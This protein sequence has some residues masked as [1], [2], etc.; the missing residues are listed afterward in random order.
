MP[1]QD[2]PGAIT[3]LRDRLSSTFE[4]LVALAHSQAP[5][6]AARPEPGGWTGAEVLEHIALTDH[7]L[8]RLAQKIGDKAAM[9]AARGDEWPTAPPEF[10]HLEAIAAREH[11]WPHPE[12]MTPTGEASLGEVAQ[13]LT[14]HLAIAHGWLE[15][16]PYGE[17]TLHRIRM[18]VVGDA[19]AEDD[20]LHLYQFLAVIELHARRHRA[21]LA[22]LQRSARGVY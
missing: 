7:F 18:S 2:W 9:R 3:A 4:P 20:R 13:E 5:W 14:E 8:L 15:R 19:G 1:P 21:Q 16:Q 11:S 17:G 22:R 10:A 6:L 12:H